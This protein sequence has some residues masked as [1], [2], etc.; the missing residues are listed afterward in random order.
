MFNE[1]FVL[2]DLP[3]YGYAKA[4]KAEQGGWEYMITSYFAQTNFLAGIIML[5]IP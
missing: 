4:S 1:D 2:V 3:G 5:V